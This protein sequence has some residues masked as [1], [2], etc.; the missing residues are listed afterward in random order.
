MVPAIE[1]QRY[2][3]LAAALKLFEVEVAVKMPPFRIPRQN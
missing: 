2:A 3:L 1:V